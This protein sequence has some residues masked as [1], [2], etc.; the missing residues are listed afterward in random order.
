MNGPY[1]ILMI[2]GMTICIVLGF[3]LVVSGFA[4]YIIKFWG[5]GIVKEMKAVSLPIASRL[6][7]AGARFGI[8]GVFLGFILLTVTLTRH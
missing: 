4:M 1:N 7:Y 6:I 2:S 3:L 8:T 5:K